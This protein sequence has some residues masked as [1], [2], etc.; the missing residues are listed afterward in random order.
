MIELMDD[1]V[2]MGVRHIVPLARS[3]VSFASA[4]HEFPFFFGLSFF[5]ECREAGV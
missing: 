1:T 5:C 3:S 2:A 4:K